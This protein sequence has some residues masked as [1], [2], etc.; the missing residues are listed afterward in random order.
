LIL[1]PSLL[2]YNYIYLNFL[3][4]VLFLLYSFLYSEV[5]EECGRFLCSEQ[6]LPFVC[7][8]HNLYVI[9][10]TQYRFRYLKGGEEGT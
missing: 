6:F 7:S 5:D 10:T 8:I 9:S 3:F 2:V 4:W 1:I